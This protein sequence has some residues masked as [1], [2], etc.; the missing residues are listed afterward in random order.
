MSKYNHGKH[1]IRV[2]GSIIIITM[3]GAFNEQGGKTLI[4]EVKHVINQ[5]DG[6]KFSILMNLLAI[7][8]GTPEAFAESE[9][10]N[11]WL[12][13]QNMVAKAIVSKSISFINIDRVRVPS[14]RKQNCRYFDT[15]KGAFNWLE[16]Q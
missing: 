12:N 10:Y 7:E 1:A 3:E 4:G 14:K 16:S 11:T 15:E 6:R 8:G 9:K 13:S 2:I 5:F